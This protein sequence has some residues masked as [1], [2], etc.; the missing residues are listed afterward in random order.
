MAVWGVALGT[1]YILWLYYRVALGEVRPAAP[2][3]APR[4]QRPRGG[5]ARSAGACWRWSSV[6]TPSPCSAFCGL[7]GTAVDSGDRVGRRCGAPVTDLRLLLPELVLVGMALALILVARHVKRARSA[8][9]SVVV[10]AVAAAGSV[11]FFSSERPRDRLR[12]H[13]RRRRLRAVFQC[14]LRGDSGPRRA[15]LGQAPRRGALFR[16]PSPTPCSCSPRQA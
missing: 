16:P 7:R 5:D 13:D 4:P 2:R 1:T 6:S 9:A 12:R 11:W 15:P 10:A 8:A 3:A 14:A